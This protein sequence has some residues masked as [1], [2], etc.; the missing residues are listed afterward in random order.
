MGRTLAGMHYYLN[1]TTK[2]SQWE[3]PTEPVGSGDNATSND[4]VSVQCSHLLVKHCDSRRASS[5]REDKIT[6]TKDQA[7]A[8]LTDYRQQIVAGDTDLERLAS[9]Y[10][11]CSSAKNG[12][13]LG[14]FRRG[15]MQRPFEEASFALAVGELSEIVD[16]DSG[17]HIIKRTA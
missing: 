16:T 11:D 6:R 9:K 8:L 3:C 1:T 5:W 7:H 4:I 15:Q 14:P 10:S 13:D 17:L 12:G 2:E